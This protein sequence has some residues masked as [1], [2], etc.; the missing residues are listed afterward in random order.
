MN[1]AQRLALLLAVP[2]LVLTGLGIF[3]HLQLASVDARGRDMADIQVPTLAIIGRV[4]RAYGELRTDVR[5]YIMAADPAQRQTIGEHFQATE[6][7]INRLFDEYARTLLVEQQDRALLQT[8]RQLVSEWIGG[9]R[10]AMTM[11]GENHGPEAFNRLGGQMRALAD[12]V[13]QA[14]VEWIK[15]NEQVA[16][17]A[18]ASM[19]AATAK[20]RNRLLI[21]GG[22]ALLLAAGLGFVTFRRI[23][24][25]IQS[26]ETS[27]Q[28]IA[29]GDYDKA[30]PYTGA[31]DETGSLARSVE[32]LKRAA[33]QTHLQSRQLEQQAAELGRV[34]LLS[35]TA[36]DLAK[37][38]YWH[39]AF[40]DPEWY[41]SSERGA[42]LLGQEP[43]PGFR[44]RIEDWKRHVRLGDAAAAE[45]AFER[46][47][48]VAAGKTSSYDATYA[49]QRPVDGRV[50]W[51]RSFGHLVRDTDGRPKEIF[52]VNQDVTE[53][54]LAEIAIKEGEQQLRQT[55]QYFRSVLER[56]P[57]GLMVVDPDGTIRLANAQCEKLFGYARD[58][59]IGQKV[60][61]LVPAAIRGRHPGL[62]ESYHQAPTTRAMG[63]K[64]ELNA[65]R[66]DGSLFPVDI[67][68][69]PLPA[70]DGS[71]T[72]V[73]VSIRN[74]TER[75]QAESELKVAKEKAEEATQ[76]KSMFLANMS[77][78]IRTPMN[79]IIGLSY[80]ALKTPLNPKQRDYVAKVHNAGTSLLA[81]I[82]D[83]LDFSKIEAGRLDLETTTFR[84]DDVI[85]SVTTLTGQKAHEKGLEFLAR[86]APGIPE[87]LLGDPLRLG[88]ILTNLVNNAT[89]FTERGEIRL[90]AEL[91]ERTGNKCQLR[92]SI[93]DTGMGMTT[94]QAER[95]FQPFVQA[96]MS[97]TRK[98]GGTGLGL[99]I[100][101][102]LVE[103]MGGQI[104]L[105]SA[106]GTGSNFTFTAW[107]GIGDQPGARK[108]I[109]A[110]L[111][112]LRVLIVDDN[113][114]AREI[115]DDLVR[116][117]VARAD[118]VASGPEA[119]SAVRQSDANTPY[120]VVFMDWRMP[121]MDGLQAT[122]II[123]SDTT[124]QHPPA[125]IMVTAF[126]R[127]DV[128]EQAERMQLD[129]FL[130][131][132]VTKSM[133]VDAL[134][135]VF[136]DEQ[137]QQAAVAT[138]RSEGVRLD[139][140]RVLLVE[141]NEINQQIA[142]ELLEGVGATLTVANNGREAV[143][144]LMGGPV[145]PAFDVVLMDL[146]MPV[147]DGHQATALLRAE[148][149]FDAL[150]IIAMTAHATVEERD[151][152]LARGMNGHIPKP[153]EPAVLFETLARLG[154]PAAPAAARP[155]PVVPAQPVPAIDGVD[156]RDGLAR[157]AGNE[158]LYLKL[159]RQFVAQQ[160]SA[161]T[162]ISAA[163]AQ[164][165][166][167]TAERLAHSLKGV[168]GNLG[169][170]PVQAAAAAVE[171]MLRERAA[172]ATLAP[173]MQELSTVLDSLLENLRAKLP[174]E[175]VEAS[176]AA[177]AD[178]VRTRVV[179]TELATL[180]ANFDAGAVDFLEANSA[181]L[182]PAFAA[183][184]W[185]AF[186]DQIKAYGFADA[187]TLLREAVPDATS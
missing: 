183:A 45:I 121:G 8:Y 168:A 6:T 115:I 85:T 55:E 170:K 46:F 114:A 165:D 159:L 40:D 123:K 27:V 2:L 153:I 70:L 89:K 44:Y 29:A 3:V 84:L 134:V 179:A 58:E 59:L 93:R 33:A 47:D 100:C 5:D 18:G 154:R 113:S 171:K 152:C 169:A 51:L 126:G 158:K 142:V 107:L 156:V 80:L 86:S 52:G 181:V 63:A 103:L 172:A 175:P 140:M 69:S 122:E 145:V 77:H 7:E 13:N 141:D 20:M 109:P 9:A 60:E 12:R 129:G 108:V 138:A 99:T 19:I 180:L 26:L 67:G 42:S 174:D 39:L 71:N 116:D 110:R 91:V 101:R 143:D 36:L 43:T 35:D 105:E 147:M 66:K 119:I 49:F 48:A 106:P 98:H 11:A 148:R 157:V 186:Q 125:V 54:R 57:D 28:A 23:V 76:M 37:A 1:V 155:A 177:P 79:A 185:T 162:Q 38:N 128:R 102:R 161:L 136:A 96:D 176:A 74:V 151:A 97:T 124:L 31:R 182:R 78:E 163:L 187:L 173:A 82:N 25:P 75:K 166:V 92:F 34:N 146:Q 4:T 41:Y 149:R 132:P 32:V 14:S 61:K 104:W 21:A 135:T 112:K 10:A 90:T 178:P 117:L 144:K 81:V 95:L 22:L 130:L 88:Q 160:G 131:K 83:I 30:V 120:D 24:T 16:D 62:R 72:Q 118:S 184:A 137:D 64:Q 15:H 127:E 150:P 111:T 87:F 94:E 133:V 68:L 164:A 17:A 50:I 53:A 139:G 73:A 56:A 65:Q 167:S